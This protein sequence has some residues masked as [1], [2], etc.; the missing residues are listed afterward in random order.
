MAA[1][2]QG[3]ATSIMSRRARIAREKLASYTIGTLGL[4]SWRGIEG[5]WEDR[6]GQQVLSRDREQVASAGSLDKFL[7]RKSKSRE[8]ELRIVGHSE[9]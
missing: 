4:R 1:S 3:V 7:R 2:V 9:R 5:E 8:S 6:A